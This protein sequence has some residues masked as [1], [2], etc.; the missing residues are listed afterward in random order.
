ML[1][2]NFIAT[3]AFHLSVTAS[4]PFPGLQ[5]SGILYGFTSLLNI[6][7]YDIKNTMLVQ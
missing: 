6:I 4:I 5:I 3:D 7:C 1:I 2:K